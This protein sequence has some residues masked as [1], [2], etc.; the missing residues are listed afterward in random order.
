M[1]HVFGK[2]IIRV[3][4]QNGIRRGVIYRSLFFSLIVFFSVT[5]LKAEHFWYVN[6]LTITEV[7]AGSGMY[8]IDYT[9]TVTFATV[10]R[11]YFELFVVES[12][13][14]FADGFVE[15]FT[16]CTLLGDLPDGNHSGTLAEGIR[17]CPGKTYDAILYTRRRGD[18]RS[19]V[20][21]GS[22]GPNPASC[23]ADVCNDVTCGCPEDRATI[24]TPLGLLTKHPAIAAGD[25]TNIWAGAPLNTLGDTPTFDG[26]WAY[27]RTTLTG[28]GL[29]DYNMSFDFQ[30]DDCFGD[31]DVTA[32]FDQTDGQVVNQ[33]LGSASVR[34]G[35]PI[36]VIYN[37]QNS[38]GV[39]F[40]GNTFEIFDNS[41]IGSNDLGSN[42]FNLPMGVDINVDGR[43]ES[44]NNAVAIGR[45]CQGGV[46]S[47]N[48][49]NSTCRVQ[50]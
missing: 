49:V 15:S 23:N 22:G 6:S 28:N 36:D 34:C 46:V 32:D 14:S 12:G 26:N 48:M 41:T 21:G 33:N 18:C 11:F 10:R 27:L 44:F 8:T 1:R 38:C 43:F 5:S 30:F 7:P 16:G 4:L 2:T 9:F 24:A 20:T 13:C 29:P 37:A 42:N 40:P 31:F 47:L 19:D 45:I 39:D 35:V 50:R 3:F 25:P 17:L